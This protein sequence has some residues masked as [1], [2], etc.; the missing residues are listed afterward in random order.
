MSAFA[1]SSLVVQWIQA[2]ATTTLT[3]DHR[4]FSVTPSISLIEQT[5]GADEFKTY[6]VGVKDG[7]CTYEAI[8][9]SGTGAGG[10]LT[11]S[12]LDKG[13][14]GTILYMPEGTAAGKT[15]GTIPAISQGVSYSFPYADVVTVSVNWQQNGADGMGTTA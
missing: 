4:N 6:I 1:G 7:N 3:G 2:A 12:T 10:T 8:L 5:A 11:F 14:L 9:Q 15:R 13:N